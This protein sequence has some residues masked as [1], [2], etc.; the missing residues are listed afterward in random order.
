MAW[1]I[2]EVDAEIH[3][4]D[5]TALLT[6]EVMAVLVDKISE[7]TAQRTAE[8]QVRQRDAALGSNRRS[9]G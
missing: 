8:N 4:F 5:A 7:A 1:K 9:E 3:A 6:D 2:N